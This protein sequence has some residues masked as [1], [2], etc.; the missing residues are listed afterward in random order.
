MFNNLLSNTGLSFDRLRNFCLVV[1]KGSIS[2]AAEG[3]VTRQSQFSRQIRELETFF[4]TELT[5]RKGKGIEITEAGRE[6]ARQVRQQLQSLE[7]F[8]QTCAD[9]PL[10]IRIVAGNSVLEWLL[11]PLLKQVSQSQLNV[12]LR[13]MSMTTAHAVESLR[14]G[15]ADLALIRKSAVKHPL[16]HQKLRRINYS[17][18][19]PKAFLTRSSNWKSLLQKHPLAVTVGG[20]F[21]QQFDTAMTKQAFTPDLRYN[22]TSF[23]QVAE[24]VRAGLSIAILPEIAAQ[25]LPSPAIKQVDFPPLAH[26]HRDI[27]QAWKP[28]TISIRPAL[29]K[30]ID[31]MACEAEPE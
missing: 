27:C 21:R 20:E 19:V 30:L 7:D 16:K 11:V 8:K 9:Q 26:Y 17:L 13:M 6:L 5:R 2:K 15:T 24:F 22:C 14:Q 1:D 4:G 25:S 23:T 31:L 18:F 12:K 3:D 28:Q 29:Q 10:E